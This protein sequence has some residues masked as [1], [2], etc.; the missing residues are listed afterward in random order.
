MRANISFF[1]FLKYSLRNEFISKYKNSALGTLWNFI[2]PLGMIIVYT[3]VFSRV[4]GARIEG[5][6]NTYAYS[7]YLCSGL[8]PWNFMSEF[9]IRGT[10][11][12]V[13]NSVVIKK[14]YM[15]KIWLIYQALAVSL[16]NFIVS[17]SI[18]IIFM[19]IMDINIIY[20]MGKLLFVIIFHVYFAT[21]VV[22]ILSLL[23]IPYRD[24]G[25]SLSILFQ[26]V[27]WI[28]PVVYLQKNVG[29]LGEII[30]FN[31]IADVI[32]LYRN[33]LYDKIQIDYQQLLL[34]TISATLLY[35]IAWL[36]EKK[37]REY[38]IDNL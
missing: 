5:V 28:T 25:Y 20:S 11:V 6:E 13:D 30:K 29:L 17:M 34:P 18:F 33:V 36:F 24:I 22:C 9:I 10:A 23:N 27:F 31:P 35:T 4:M 26:I 32:G 3:M 16:I 37:N 21:S 12:F 19:L 14:I 1:E 38:L 8:L 15:P 7:I 2:Y